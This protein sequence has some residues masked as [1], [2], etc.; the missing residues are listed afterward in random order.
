MRLIFTL[1][2][3]L[4]ALPAFASSVITCLDTVSVVGKSAE[5]WPNCK[6]LTK[7]T[8]TAAKEVIV[9]TTNTGKTPQWVTPASAQLNPT[10]Y[11]F[12]GV[13]QANGLDWA[14]V[15]Q[16]FNCVTVPPPVTPPPPPPAPTVGQAS[17]TW[18]PS[19]TAGVS[20]NVYRGASATSY[21][22]LAQGVSSPYADKTP[23]IGATYTYLVTAS[24][25]NGE[26]VAFASPAVTIKA[27]T[28]APAAAA[29][30][31]ATSP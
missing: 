2:A 28:A 13:V 7:T 9:S 29:A 19:A 11:V 17:L 12:T 20:Y 1:V 8:A 10:W 27:P 23:L 5:P 21:A 30:V 6:S 18:S 14:P 3:L 4:A 26:S 31:K 16:V 15:C 25:A 24:N 22:P